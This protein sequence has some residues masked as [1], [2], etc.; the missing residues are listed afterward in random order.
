[1][2]ADLAARLQVSVASQL[3][4][5]HIAFAPSAYC[6][7]LLLR[8]QLYIMITSTLCAHCAQPYQLQ[9][10]DVHFGA[11]YHQCVY[12]RIQPQP[13]VMH[14]GAETRAAYG[15]DR[16]TTYMPHLSLL[17]SDID[18]DARCGP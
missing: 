1:M 7:S 10:Q 6:S 12:I 14:A 11:T 15:G 18:E 4:H 13:N 2:A 8:E 17:Y 3:Y 9:F 16:D 5:V